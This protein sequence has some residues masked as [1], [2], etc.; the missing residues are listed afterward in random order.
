VKQKNTP[1]PRDVQSMSAGNRASSTSARHH[2]DFNDDDYLVVPCPA[3][4][5]FRIGLFG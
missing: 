2:H 5:G 3:E 4:P 1:Q